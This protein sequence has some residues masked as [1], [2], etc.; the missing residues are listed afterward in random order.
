VP[1]IVKSGAFTVKFTVVECAS[2]P[3]APFTVTVYLGPGVDATVVTVSVDGV[4]GFTDSGLT[5]HVGPLVL[6]GVTAQV[7]VTA[8]LNPFSAVTLTV[9][10]DEFPGITAGGLNAVAATTKSGAFTVRL[11][12]TVLATPFDV[13]LT[14]I[15]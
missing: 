10:V 7:N 11:T 12:E 4:P 15:M 6:T 5:A 2:A 9:E 13:P 3:D 1:E 8:L 14:V